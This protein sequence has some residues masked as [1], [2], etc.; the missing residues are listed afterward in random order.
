MTQYIKF[1][2]D[3]LSLQLGY[4][5]IY[6]VE[7]CFEWMQ[8]ISIQSKKNFFEKTP[9]AYSLANKTKTD[10]VFEFSEDF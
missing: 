4:P 1:V 8:L 7:N 10:D 6:N 5:K 9:D 3:R 2:A